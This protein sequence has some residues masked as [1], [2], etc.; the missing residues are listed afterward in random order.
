MTSPTRRDRL[1]GL[2]AT[3]TIIAV[4]A[5]IP[6]VLVA[7]GANPL[8]WDLPTPDQVGSALTRP[9]DG[10]LA[11]TAVA[12]LAWLAWA[13]LTLTLLLEIGARLR[14]VRA[15]R[16]PGLALPQSAAR[17]L[18]SFQTA[19]VRAPASAPMPPHLPQP[20]GRILHGP[21]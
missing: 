10:T 12:V 8:T 16:L 14:G 5:G 2:A 13:F 4:I 19:R 3:A 15:S 9:D 11:L 1:T 21:A 17:G 6:T 18:A 7:I 20:P